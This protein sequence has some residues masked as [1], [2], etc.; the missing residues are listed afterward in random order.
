M[1]ERPCESQHHNYYHYNIPHEL[2]REPKEWLFEVIV[3]LGRDLEVLEILLAMECH[4]TG[5]NFSLL[6]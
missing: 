3:G 6:W 5:F 4:R 1:K 2:S